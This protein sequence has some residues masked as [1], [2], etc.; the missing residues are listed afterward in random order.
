MKQP[1]K[2]IVGLGKTGLS[3]VRYLAQQNLNIAVVDSRENPP[4]LTELK[5]Q[6]PQVPIYLGGFNEEIISQAKELIVSPGIS[7]KEPLIAKQIAKG[8]PAIGDIE[9]FARTAKAPLVAITGTNGKSTVTTLVGEMAKTAG[10]NVKVG[11]NLGTPALDLLDD[12]AE[13]YVLELSSF[14]LETIHSLKTIAA[15]V[16]NISPDHMDRYENLNEYISAKQRIYQHC[17]NPVINRNDPASFSGLKDLQHAISFGLEKPKNGEFGLDGNYLAYGEK[18]LLTVSELQIKGRQNIAN[19]LAALALGHAANLPM[20]AMLSTLKT[21][22]GLPHRCQWVANTA[23][24]DWY[25]DSKGT[26]VSSTLAAIDGLGSVISGKLIL[27][28]GG[29]GKQQDFSPLIQSV[30]NYVREV[31]LIGEDAQII[32]TALQNS[33]SVTFAENLQEAV[34][35]SRK[36][37]KKGDAILLSPACASFDMFNNFEHRGEVFMSLVRKLSTANL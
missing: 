20:I 24:I 16:L 22:Q 13:L 1:L 35:L 11:G 3:C 32:A 31:I 17:E 7:L 36:V 14:Q 8:I 12:K 18:K 19:A 27:I 37:A 21:F 34:Q 15:A 28:A 10:L 9:L 5:N 26:N 4:G 25:N 2:L 6:F 33:T 30:K 23:G 29:Q